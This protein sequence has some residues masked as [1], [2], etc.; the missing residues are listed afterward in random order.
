MSTTPSSLASHLDNRASL[1]RRILSFHSTPKQKDYINL[2]S[3]SKY[4]FRCTEASNT[5][6]VADYGCA[7]LASLACNNA[8]NKKS[9]AEAGGIAMILSMMEQ[10]GV[11]NAEVAKTGCWALW[12][13]IA[14]AP[15][16]E[17]I[18]AT[19]RINVENKR[20]ILAANGVSM[21]E[22]MKATW[23]SNEDV[24]EMAGGALAILRN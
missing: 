22:R 18:G 16:T 3:T 17:V 14:D 12:N 2:R 13:L 15:N 5:G 21:V 7:A 23:A 6:T 24:Q 20:K 10:H 19:G 8:D 4:F 9:I 1:L 11:S